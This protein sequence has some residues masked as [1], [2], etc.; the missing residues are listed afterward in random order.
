MIFTHDEGISG[1]NTKLR[2]LKALIT[3]KWY[4]ICTITEAHYRLLK[5]SRSLERMILE[6]KAIR[7]L[8]FKFLDTEY[9]VRWRI[10][11]HAWLS[12]LHSTANAWH[13]TSWYSRLNAAMINFPSKKRALPLISFHWLVVV[14]GRSQ[15]YDWLCLYFI[16]Y[17]IVR[18][19]LQCI[20]LFKM[21][22]THWYLIIRWCI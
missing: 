7:R 15:E 22:N 4:C 17:S 18:A 3:D 14:A 9:R 19:L 13:F 2:R 16:C 11:R 5:I 12:I 8:P 6:I 1:N 10:L 20:S 21:H